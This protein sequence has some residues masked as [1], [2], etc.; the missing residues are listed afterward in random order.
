M[1]AANAELRAIFV[2]YTMPPGQFTTTPPASQSNGRLRN[3]QQLIEH[4]EMVSLSQ[5]ITVETRDLAQNMARR[6]DQDQADNNDL[7]CNRHLMKLHKFLK[8][9][10]ENPHQV[11]PQLRLICTPKSCYKE[12]IRCIRATKK[13]N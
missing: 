6:K 3:S 9:I 5:V 4:R 2:I 13:T 8:A 1:R 7:K 12:P 11:M 10:H